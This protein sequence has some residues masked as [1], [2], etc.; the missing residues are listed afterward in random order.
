MI[1]NFVKGK[2][3]VFIDAANIFYSQKNLN[4]QIDF[5][6]LKK[7]L[8]KETDIWKIFFYSSYQP[9][10]TKE[11][12][13]FNF[14]RMNGYIIKSK[15]LKYIKTSKSDGYHKGN[16]DVELTVDAVHNK[17]KYKSFL[18]FSGD[19]DFSPLIKYLKS[20][21]KRCYVFAFKKSVSIDLINVARIINIKQLKNFICKEDRQKNRTVN[22]DRG[23]ERDR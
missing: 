11:V 3:A 15:K 10:K 1:R 12:K 4:W 17:D 13:F 21:K 19:G 9:G 6:R 8:E 20:H 16:L 14:L 23:F 7:Y 18:L 22:K 2:T 5:L